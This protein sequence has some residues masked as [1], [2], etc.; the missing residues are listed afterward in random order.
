MGCLYGFTIL[1]IKVSILLQYLRIFS[2][3]KDTAFYVY[4]ILIWLIMVYYLVYAFI[5]IFYCNPVEKNWKPWIKGGHC[6]DFKTTNIVTATFNSTS[7]IIILIAPQKVI[8]NL[9]MSLKK[10]IGVSA[11]FFVGSL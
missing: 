9:Q 10:K 8:W 5:E 3:R 2:T 7:D 6:M 1:T 11:I 4:H